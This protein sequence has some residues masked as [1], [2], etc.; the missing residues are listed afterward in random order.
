MTS[1][2]ESVLNCKINASDD[3]HFIN[4]LNKLAKKNGET[5]YQSIIQILTEINLEPGEAKKCWF[6][7][8]T[9]RD[10]ISKAL[11][12]QTSL[13]TAVSDYFD[14]FKTS[15]KKYKL[16]EIN[17]YAQAIKESNHDNFTGLFNKVFFQNTLNQHISLAN[18]N[19]SDLSVLFLDI[20]DFKEINDTFGHHSGDIIL[21]NVAQTIK[22][23]L[24]SSD[25]AA[26]FG[27]DEFVILMPNT[28]K[29][30]ALL[31]SERLRKT[32]M[33]KPMAIQD[34][35]LQITVSGGVAGFPVDDQKAENL[36][37]MADSALY[38]AKGAGKN[39]ISLFKED[40]RRF[41]RI[42]F[43]RPIK[44][45]Q[46]GFSRTRTLSGR[47]KDIAVGGILFENPEPL[48]IG[49][50][51]Q[52]NIPIIEDSE[53]VLLIGTVVRVEAFGSKKYDI[54]M[55]LSFKEMEK[56]AKNE[57]SKFLVQQSKNDD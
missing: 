33:K 51:I 36:L 3:D 12:K 26:R 35:N 1:I 57:I 10:N 42:K 29:I 28:H 44:I 37:N 40:K 43:K 20:D 9:H 54:G 22:Q 17:A 55:I 8:I 6:E 15:F 11:K 27:G 34:S 14:S 46:L 32:I 45:K 24:R 18:R 5:T 4:E 25:I 48:S 56:T 49:T 52:V 13:I 16:I 19:N 50:K 30:N 21:K 47:S 7:I 2:K 31:L 23:E 53:P 39:R 41:L 38:R